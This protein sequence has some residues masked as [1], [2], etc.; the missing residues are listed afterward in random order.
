M[1]FGLERLAVRMAGFWRGRR[2]APRRRVEPRHALDPARQRMIGAGELL[3]PVLLLTGV[4]LAV[5]ISAMA[6]IFSAYEYRRLFNQHQILV[7]QWDELQVEWGQYLLEQSV[8]SSQQRI[9]SLA[10]HEMDMVVPKTEAIEIVRHE[11]E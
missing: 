7:Q 2:R 11:Q 4:T 9:E 5:V 3:A 6:V 8:W 10:S 1:R